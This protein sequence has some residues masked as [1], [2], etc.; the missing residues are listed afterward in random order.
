MD[1]RSRRELALQITGVSTL[2]RA[3]P[4]AAKADPPPAPRTLPVSPSLL[5]GNVIAL[6][7]PDPAQPLHETMLEMLQEARR[8]GMSHT[9]DPLP[10]CELMLEIH[11][12]AGELLGTP[13]A[14]CHEPWPCKTVLGILGG[15][16]PAV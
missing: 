16:E 14:A 12:P 11:A 10:A 4:P 1:L 5:T 8:R 13:C 6:P 9:R 15:L 2:V 7:R 3:R